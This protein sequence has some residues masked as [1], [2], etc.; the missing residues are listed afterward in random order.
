MSDI[1][2]NIPGGGATAALLLELVK[3]Q[4]AAATEL[5]LQNARLFGGDGQ[6]G[7]IPTLFAQHQ[8]L[9]EE[10]NV[11]LDANK[12]ELVNKIEAVKDDLAAKMTT[13][14]TEIEDEISDLRTDHED[15]DKKVSRFGTIGAT[16][17]AMLVIG[18]SAFGIWHK[19]GH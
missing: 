9:A 5:R 18:L 15:L 14:K 6:P 8:K 17:Q 10:L 7:A 13:Q 3:G 16:I 1:E 2:L 11:K 4:Q 19:A 12:T